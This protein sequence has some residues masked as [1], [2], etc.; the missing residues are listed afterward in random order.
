MDTCCD[1]V[2]PL[3]PE[4]DSGVVDPCSGEACAA[5][6]RFKF[7]PDSAFSGSWDLTDNRIEL[8]VARGT[9]QVLYAGECLGRYVDGDDALSAT[10]LPCVDLLLR[11]PAGRQ[12]LLPIPLAGD[13]T[14]N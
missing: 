14:C 6:D 5:C 1:G 12:L 3:T 4:C 8:S 10:P 9:G 2:D 11:D 7:V 13:F